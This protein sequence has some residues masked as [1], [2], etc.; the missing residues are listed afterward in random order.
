[1][2]DMVTP[3]AV[4]VD[5]FDVWS[6]FHQVPCSH[7]WL[8]LGQTDLFVGASGDF[9]GLV[10]WKRISRRRMTQCHH[11]KTSNRRLDLCSSSLNSCNTGFSNNDNDNDKRCVSCRNSAGFKIL[12][13]FQ[14]LPRQNAHWL[15]G[16]EG[17]KAYYL[18]NKPALQQSMK[19][20]T[21]LLNKRMSL[22]W[23]FLVG[24]LT[25]QP[26]TETLPNT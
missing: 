16:G 2:V 14:P 23:L 5:V 8:T 13:A 6:A 11:K 26:M 22:P 9:G 10:T 3:L 17:E 20:K 18:T 21:R 1:M 4:D 24:F 12:L 19:M 25:L 7:Q 15:K